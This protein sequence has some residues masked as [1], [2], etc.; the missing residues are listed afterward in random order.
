MARILDY[1]KIDLPMI[2]YNSTPQILIDVISG[3]LTFGP[4]DPTGLNL[5]RAGKVRPIAFSG[6]YPVYGFER[7]ELYKNTVPGLV[8]ENFLGLWVPAGTPE[9]II[10]YYNH[11]F[12]NAVASKETQDIIAQR[13]SRTLDLNTSESDAYIGRAIQM[14]KPLVERYY[15]PEN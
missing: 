15:R 8:V 5:A 13:G 6:E 2:R 7:V 3:T 4:T 12:R 9:H 10:T 11:I 14:W 1:F